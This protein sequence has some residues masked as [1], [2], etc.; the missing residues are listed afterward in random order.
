[1]IVILKYLIAA[2]I[3]N[4]SVV[5]LSL[6]FSSTFAK[7]SLSLISILTTLMQSGYVLNVLP[8]VGT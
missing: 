4:P 5:I 6:G 3:M 8:I 2:L 7:G 1:M